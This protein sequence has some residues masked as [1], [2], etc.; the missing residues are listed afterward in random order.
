ME[1]MNIDLLKKVVLDLRKDR[2]LNN[3]ITEEEETLFEEK[4]FPYYL[5]VIEN[6]KKI[7][8]Q[9]LSSSSLDIERITKLMECEATICMI[10]NILIYEKFTNHEDEINY[11]ERNKQFIF[12]DYVDNISYSFEELKNLS[13]FAMFYDQYINKK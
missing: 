4:I 13:F 5:K 12:S 3:E 8:D 2:Y 7:G 6:Q 11:F 1:W 10:L 9:V